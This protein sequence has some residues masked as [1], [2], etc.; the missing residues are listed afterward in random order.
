MNTA[1]L[2]NTLAKE[3]YKLTPARKILL[4][5]FSSS[6]DKLHEI[7]EIYDKA[8]TY[9]PSISFSTIYRNLEMLLRCGIIEKVDLA[10]TAAY[11]M[12]GYA[13]HCH[14]LICTSCHKAAPLCFCPL[15]E[16]EKR[17][18][19]QGGF[20]PLRHKVEILGLCEDCRKN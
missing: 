3:G 20:L 6:R 10:G 1:E 2:Y 4:G 8:R 5:I 7:P 14:L 19:A 13:G 11:K 15:E 9:L 12:R 16:L 17:L 18:I